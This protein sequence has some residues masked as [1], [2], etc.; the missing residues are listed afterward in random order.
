M[1]DSSTIYLVL[2]PP[3]T[4]VNQG[5]GMGCQDF[6]GYHAETAVTTA[7]NVV[8][9]VGCACPG[10]DGPSI[11][12]LQERT[13]AISHELVEAATDPFPFS[14]PAYAQTDNADIVWSLDTGGELADMC[15][16]NL[17]SYAV[18]AGSTYMVQRSWSNKAAKASANPCVPVVNTA[19]PYF[20]SMPVLPDMVTVSGGGPTITTPG[21]KIAVGASKTIDV[22]LF[23]DAPTK[24]PWKV[25]AYDMSA[26]L[27]GPKELTLSLD[28]DTGQ[29]G[30]TLHLTITVVKADTQFGVGSFAL[31]SDLG[32]AENLSISAVGQ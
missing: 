28:K 13:V 6:D 16:F 18:P 30:D 31:F 26:V 19:E 5:G 20:N 32:G 25:T 24:G 10:F 21:V 17:D 9:A 23:S 14:N 8:Y 15:E 3:G 1:A 29:N 4:I 27:G 2:M 22:T 11:T 7:L 12:N